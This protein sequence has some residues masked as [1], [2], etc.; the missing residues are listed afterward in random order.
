[1][2]GGR[3]ALAGGPL[4]VTQAALLFE[5]GLGS[6]WPG[7]CGGRAPGLR[8]RNWKPILPVRSDRPG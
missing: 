6:I 5:D 8:R 2:G 4:K 1:M 3:G 7:S